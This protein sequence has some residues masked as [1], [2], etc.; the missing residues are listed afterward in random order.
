MT[1]GRLARD[2]GTAAK[3]RILI[4]GPKNDGT[5][6]VKFRTAEGDVLAI[7][8]PRTETAV[9]RHFQERM[10]YGLFVTAG[11]PDAGAEILQRQPRHHG[12]AGEGRSQ[13]RG[14]A[15]RSRRLQSRGGQERYTKGDLNGLTDRADANG[16]VLQ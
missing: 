9:I 12:A 11:Q 8:I 2:I 1:T 10:R 6:V 4:Y 3:N 13:Q 14:L 16:E 15:A 5:Y 7:S